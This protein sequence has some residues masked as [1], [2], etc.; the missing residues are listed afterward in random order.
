MQMLVFASKGAFTND[1]INLGGRGFGKDDAKICK[2]LPVMEKYHIEEII[3][4]FYS[5]E[6][7]Y[8][9]LAIYT[10]NLRL[11]YKL[12]EIIIESELRL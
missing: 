5:Q 8:P 11:V 7:P 9:T 6:F 2:Y 3:Y 10:L 4:L 1:V 12:K